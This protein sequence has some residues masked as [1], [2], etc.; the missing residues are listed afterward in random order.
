MNPAPLRRLVFF[1]WL[2]LALSL[3]AIAAASPPDASLRALLACRHIA[4]GAARLACFD[5]TSAALALPPPS[6]PAPS[7]GVA[8]PAMK[9]ALD[10]HRTF[11]L[12][13]ATIVRREASAAGIRVKNL[14]RITAHIVRTRQGPD[15]GAIFDLDNG[16]VWQQLDPDGTDMYTKPGDSVEITRGLLG[17]YWLDTPS[18][19]RCNVVRVR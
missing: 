8:A 14:S 1:F 16:Q 9:A 5:R 10:P 18:R 13:S 4:P 15:G 6:S 2:C 12:P 7:S 11:G 3:S 19:H 17:S